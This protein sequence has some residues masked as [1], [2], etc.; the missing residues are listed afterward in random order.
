[1]Y[2]PKCGKEMTEGIRFCPSCGTAANGEPASPGSPVVVIKEKSGCGKGCLI[3]VILMAVIGAL[4]VLVIGGAASE[5]E[6]QEREEMQASSNVTA[7]EATK[8][9]EDLVSWIRGKGDQTEL[10]RDDSFARLKGKTV[11]L[12]GKVRE[13][14]KTVF[15]EELYV[16][17]TVG[18]L[19]AFE[20]INVQFNMRETQRDKV[21]SWNQGEVHTIR[22]RITEQ[23]DL[24]DDAKCD[25]GEIVE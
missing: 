4:L 19:N 3:A 15:S 13:V 8:N 22:G 14:G 11:M 10:M 24:Q 1:M 18:Q 23:G 25:L 2:C 5:A 17:L 6:E 7:E 9:G 16:S 21:K 12:K 20:R